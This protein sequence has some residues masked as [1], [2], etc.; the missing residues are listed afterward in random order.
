M[1]NSRVQREKSQ[2]KAF[3]AAF[4][5]FRHGALLRVLRQQ[6]GRLAAVL[7]LLSA[8]LLVFNAR[9][10][11]LCAWSWRQA[12]CLFFWVYTLSYMVLCTESLGSKALCKWH[13]TYIHSLSCTLTWG[14][15]RRAQCGLEDRGSSRQALIPS[16]VLLHPSAAGPHYTEWYL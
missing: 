3:D 9:L 14:L 4:P 13:Y 16:R 10:A 5:G 15:Y 11:A 7:P 2:F 12:S 1:L 8:S 6:R